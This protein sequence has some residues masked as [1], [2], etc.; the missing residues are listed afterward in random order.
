MKQILT[1]LVVILI[2]L[3]QII[4]AHPIG[5]DT[6]STS[7]TLSVESIDGTSTIGYEYNQARE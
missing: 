3:A 7:S 2:A 4:L 1:I 5:N 6:L